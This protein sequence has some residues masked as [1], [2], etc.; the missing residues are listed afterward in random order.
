MARYDA[1]SGECSVLTFK[2][3]MLSAV[4]HDLE[5]RLRA[6]TVDVH[7]ATHALD[8]RF[9]LK[10]LRVLHAM[11]D[12]RAAPS[13][14]SD[15]DKREIERN[16]EKDVLDSRRWPEARFVSKAVRAD[17]DAWVIEGELTLC[18]KTREV[19]TRAV[20]VGDRLEA[21]A[22]LHQPHFGITPYKAM[23]GTLR[24][25]PDVEVRLSIPAPA[26]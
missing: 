9:E 1:T 22:R 26:R 5:L 17:G 19:R 20:R 2:E 12:G 25:Q 8:A 3:G 13:A 15:K 18:G 4:A 16:L 24:V 6:F 10:S 23:L 7:D 11:K 14:L 21:R